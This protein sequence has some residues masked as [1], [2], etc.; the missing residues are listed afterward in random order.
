MR[1]CFLH[2]SIKNVKAITRSH[3]ER[4]PSML[5]FPSSTFKLDMDMDWFAFEVS[6]KLLIRE[7]KQNP[8]KKLHLAAN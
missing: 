1:F 6:S 4:T 2:R 5:L 3:K 8:Q 7:I